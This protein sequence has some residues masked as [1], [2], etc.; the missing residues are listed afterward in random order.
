MRVDVLDD[1]EPE[2]IE[3]GKPF[4]L[5]RP[6][7]LDKPEIGS[8]TLAGPKHFGEIGLFNEWIERSPT[9]VQCEPGI[10]SSIRTDRRHRHCDHG[11][12][13]S[14]LVKDAYP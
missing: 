12:G 9:K 2:R 8:D 1:L 6:P 7:E 4:V 14:K 13:S 3:F 11:H 5:S 10:G